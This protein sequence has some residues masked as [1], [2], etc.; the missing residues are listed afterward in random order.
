MSIENTFPAYE[1]LDQLLHQ[2][3]VALTAA[4]MH[5]LISGML[6]GGNSDSQ[7]IGTVY[8]LVHLL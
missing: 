6:C 5:G 4:E 3:Q 2:Q 1:G 7:L 8:Q